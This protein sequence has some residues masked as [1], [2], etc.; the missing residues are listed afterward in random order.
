MQKYILKKNKKEHDN[1][2]LDEMQ[3]YIKTRKVYD[4]YDN[5]CLDKMHTNKRQ[6]TM[7]ITKTLKCLDRK[8]MK[9]IT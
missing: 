7:I 4:Y 3:R 5:R 1:M 6:E 2:C 8:L 9:T